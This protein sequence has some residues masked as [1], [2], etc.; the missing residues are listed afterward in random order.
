[1]VI[2]KCCFKKA[3]DIVISSL[4]SWKAVSDLYFSNFR[5]DC[6]A[7]PQL[8]GKCDK[9]L[10]NITLASGLHL[11]RNIYLINGEGGWRDLFHDRSSVRHFFLLYSIRHIFQWLSLSPFPYLFE[12]HETQAAS[13]SDGCKPNISRINTEDIIWNTLYRIYME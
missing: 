8:P 5:C 10:F 11:R 7:E 3:K 13:L 9:M 6:R 12:E 4:Y 1:M 2:S